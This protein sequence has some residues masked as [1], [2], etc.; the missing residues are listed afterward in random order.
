M[1]EYRKPPC[2]LMEKNKLGKGG[3]GAVYIANDGLSACKV[4]SVDE[5]LPYATKIKRYKRFC[6]EIEIQKELS[7]QMT[8]VLPVIDFCFPEKMTKNQPAWFLMPKA[9]RF[10]LHSPKCF[11][12]KLCDVIELGKIIASLHSYGMA[13]R[14][15]KPENILWFNNQIHLSDYGLVW[16][17][18]KSTLTNYPERMGPIKIMPPEL[19]ACEDLNG[20]L[21][22]KSDV[23]LF[24][25][26]A[27]M[28]LKNDNNGF[29][30]PYNRSS[31]QIYLKKEMFNCAS[32]E[33]FHAMMLEA[34]RDD[35]NMRIDISDCLRYLE[36]QLAIVREEVNRDELNRNILCENLSRFDERLTPNIKIYDELNGI[37]AL[38]DSVVSLVELNLCD[39]AKHQKIFPIR[40]KHLQDRLFE[41]CE[42]G[43]DGASRRTFLNILRAE[44]SEMRIVLNLGIVESKII[45]EKVREHD[46]VM[47]RGGSATIELGHF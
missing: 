36:K 13:H 18:G 15:I 10:I 19:E 1:P 40:Y 2:E 46:I 42:E 25:K 37:D 3:N 30:G 44:K 38:L 8:G 20:I 7:V 12:D 28:Y 35:W 31:E 6:T 32:L 34:T 22:Y 17:D 5:D 43:P 9:E 41:L 11:A 16:V 21:Y 47:R 39:E 23:Y 14:D 27:W 33:P 4:F 45:E 26:V 29:K 24:V